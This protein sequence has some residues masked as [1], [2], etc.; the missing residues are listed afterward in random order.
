MA[1][2]WPCSQHLD[3]GSR[4]NF[5]QSVFHGLYVSFYEAVSLRVVWAQCHA[6]KA[7][8]VSEPPQCIGAEVASMS[9]TTRCGTPC[10]VKRDHI[11][12]MTAVLVTGL[13]IT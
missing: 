12:A 11:F 1:I 6:I 3:V 5:L 7:P 13:G 4:P 9:L 8:L 10:S 2:D